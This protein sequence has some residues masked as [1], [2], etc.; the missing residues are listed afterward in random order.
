MRSQLYCRSVTTGPCG[1]I[2]RPVKAEPVDAFK[3]EDRSPTSDRLASL[4]GTRDTF[5]LLC[6][7]LRRNKRRFISLLLSGCE[8]LDLFGKVAKETERRERE[9]RVDARAWFDA[10]I[11]IVGFPRTPGGRAWVVHA[12]LPYARHR[13]WNGGEIF[14]VNIIPL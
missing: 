13:K 10:K 8:P 12:R 4:S 9:K 3:N 5:S 11:K 14:T 6:L 1:T 7:C 2:R